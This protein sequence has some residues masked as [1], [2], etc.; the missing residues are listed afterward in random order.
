MLL[1]VHNSAFGNQAPTATIQGQGSIGRMG[2]STMLGKG[3]HSM[4]C[5][6]QVPIFDLR[7]ER[8]QLNLQGLEVPLGPELVFLPRDLRLSRKWTG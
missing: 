2:S 5:G 8:C 1:L 7:G 6:H 3:H 4:G